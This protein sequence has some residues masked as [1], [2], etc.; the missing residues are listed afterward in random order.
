MD[1]DRKIEINKQRNELVVKSNDL[2]RNTRYNL[3]VME[4]KIVIY[5]ISKIVAEDTDFKKVELSV[6][7]YCD[8]CGIDKGGRGY[9]LVKDSIKSLRDKSW[10]IQTEDN[11]EVLFSWIDTARVQKN[12]GTVEVKL[13]ESLRPYLLQLKGNFTKYELINTLMLKS[14]YAIRLYEL[15]KSYLWLGK[16]EV[17]IDELKEILLIGE[18]Y[19]DYRD[20]KKFVINQSIKEINTYTDLTISYD[21]KKNG[22]RIDKLVFQINEKRGVQLTL[23]LI[24]NQEERLN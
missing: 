23:D 24:L 20:F 18:K 2:I 15:F 7:D 17:S 16:W 11:T 8:L 22:R 6:K 12:N 4:Q 13:S 1:K 14:R 5:L 10:W 21:V 9:Q 19:K 3:S